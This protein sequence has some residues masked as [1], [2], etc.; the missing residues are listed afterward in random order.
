MSKN[1]TN[2]RART[3]ERD[4][5]KELARQLSVEQ[6]QTI[7]TPEVLRRTLNIPTLKGVLLEDAK[8]KRFQR[9]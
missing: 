8:A 1:L 2:V 3:E 5:L 4:K 6:K 7:G 9:K